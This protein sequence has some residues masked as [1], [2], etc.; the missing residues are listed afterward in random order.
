MKINKITQYLFKKIGMDRLSGVVSILSDSMPVRKFVIYKD[1]IA[2][3]QYS[4]WLIGCGL[5]IYKLIVSE[6][7]P[8]TAWMYLTDDPKEALVY[9]LFGAFG[10][11]YIMFFAVYITKFVYNLLHGGIESIFTSKWYSLAKSISYLVL[12]CFAFSYVENIKMAGHTMYYQVS[13]VIRTSKQHEDDAA[14]NIYSLKK[15]LDNIDKVARK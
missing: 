14:K 8:N 2:L 12:L 7:G 4:L 3:Y 11:I 13:H 6:A 15:L 10:F 9:V 1:H 5:W